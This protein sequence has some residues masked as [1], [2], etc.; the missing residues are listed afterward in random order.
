MKCKALAFALV[1]A[2]RMPK[3]SNFTFYLYKVFNRFMPHVA[4]NNFLF[5]PTA[6]IFQGLPPELT[7]TL[8][9]ASQE[10]VNRLC[11]KACLHHG[12]LMT[13]STTTQT[14]HAC[15]QY[16]PS[17]ITIVLLQVN[18]LKKIYVSTKQMM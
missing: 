4:D 17:L 8:A 15:A 2:Y 12:L 3:N 16:M 7:R 11:N 6:T 5:E 9:G 13:L 1:H 10:Q 14:K 18:V